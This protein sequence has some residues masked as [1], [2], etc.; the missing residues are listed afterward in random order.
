MR[1]L[2]RGKTVE[3]H[4]RTAKREN[5]PDIDLRDYWKEKMTR[6]IST[7]VRQCGE[8][9]FHG[10]ERVVTGKCNDECCHNWRIIREMCSLTQTGPNLQI[11]EFS[12]STVTYE[13]GKKK[14]R[15]KTP[16]GNKL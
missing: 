2:S 8:L 14:A 12:T 10:D 15:E 6:F 4:F 3:H 11:S 5:C 16:E 9:C 1:V 7:F 13:K